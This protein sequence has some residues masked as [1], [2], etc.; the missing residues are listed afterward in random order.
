MLQI[1]TSNA[2]IINGQA[3]GLCLSQTRDR[4]V[5]YT[6]ES[7]SSGL[8]YKEHAMPHARY[9]AAHDAPASGVAGR[10]QLEADVLDLLKTL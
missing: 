1:S 10:T 2:I 9:S 6:P 8:A 7:R 4:T 5:I 3:T